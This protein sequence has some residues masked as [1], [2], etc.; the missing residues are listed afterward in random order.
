MKKLIFLLITI[1][2]IFSC[3]RIYLVA[4]PIEQEKEPCSQFHQYIP[5]PYPPW[6]PYILEDTLDLSDTMEFNKFDIYIDTDT[7]YN[8]FK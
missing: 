4:I 8:K 2:F 1:L 3:T 5:D 6:F 7:V